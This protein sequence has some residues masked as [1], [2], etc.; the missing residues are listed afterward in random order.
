[1]QSSHRA[2]TVKPLPQRAATHCDLRMAIRNRENA[3]ADCRLQ[4][5]MSLTTTCGHV[6]DNA[7]TVTVTRYQPNREILYCISCIIKTDKDDSCRRAAVLVTTLLLQGLGK[8]A[9]VDLGENLVPLYRSLKHLRDT[10][11]DPTVQ[12]HAQLALE[13]FD[14]IVKHYLFAP[15]KLEKTIF[16]LSN[17]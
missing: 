2:R 7:V 6:V 12:L 5:R 8:S 9:L 16:L 15:P 14:D 11:N 10:D 4:A 13:E 17:N 1:M 3:R